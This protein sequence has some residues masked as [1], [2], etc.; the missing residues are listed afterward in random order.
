MPP[1]KHE[2]IIKHVYYGK[3]IIGNF[4]SITNDV[5]NITFYHHEH[6]N[7]S[8]YPEG[9]KYGE[10]P[11]IVRIITVCD[12]FCALTEKRAYREALTKEIAFHKIQQRSNALYDKQVVDSLEGILFL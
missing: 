11:M 10:I 4:S 6:L 5:K 8:G 7:G 1:E 9:L 3:E 12:V 2:I